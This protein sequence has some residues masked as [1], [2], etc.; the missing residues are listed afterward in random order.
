MRI[1][2]PAFHEI[3][4]EVWILILPSEPF[5]RRRQRAVR[6]CW[7]NDEHIVGVDIAFVAFADTEHVTVACGVYHGIG[8]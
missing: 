2:A 7:R 6:P 8:A 3:L 5:V 4:V 1:F